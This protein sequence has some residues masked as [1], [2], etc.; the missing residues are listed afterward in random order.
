MVFP[1]GFFYRVAGRAPMESNYNPLKPLGFFF[2]GRIVLGTVDGQVKGKTAA[3]PL[4]GA[5]GFNLPSMERY[6]GA[7]ERQ[8]DSHP[9]GFFG[10]GGGDD[11]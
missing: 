11:G 6:K 3:F 4:T 7:A 5:F 1:A 9:R 2:P 10:W 8:A